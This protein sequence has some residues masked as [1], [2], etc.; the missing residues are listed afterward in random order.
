VALEYLGHFAGDLFANTGA[1]DLL[2][3]VG[4]H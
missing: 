4:Q 2:G 1:I 3:D